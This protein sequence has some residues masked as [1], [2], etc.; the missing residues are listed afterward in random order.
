[1]AFSILGPFL[2]SLLCFCVCF[3]YPASLSF[4]LLLDEK[5][6]PSGALKND[7]LQ[8]VMFWVLCSWICCIET[9][10]PLALLLQYLPFYY[11][12]KCVLFY[13]LASPQFKG[14][15]W[16]WLHAICPA[17]EKAAPMCSQL[18]KEH[19]PPQLKVAIEKATSTIM[20][21]KSQHSDAFNKSRQPSK[22]VDTTQKAD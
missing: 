17:Y 19:C 16:I 6:S 11:E 1:M 14:A 5:S 21:L 2:G 7:H 9:F 8:H 10:P 3:V 22:T 4:Q 13:W 18:Y 15:G 12:M 20:G